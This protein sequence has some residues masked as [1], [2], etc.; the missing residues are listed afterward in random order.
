M[1]HILYE[2]GIELKGAGFKLDVTRWVQSLCHLS[3]KSIL[4]IKFELSIFAGS[5]QIMQY[6]AY[7]GTMLIRAQNE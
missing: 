2:A 4:K 3:T 7:T 5:D 6:F 1:L